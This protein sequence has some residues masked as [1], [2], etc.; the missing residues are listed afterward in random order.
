MYHLPAKNFLAI[1][2]ADHSRETHF[3]SVDFYGGQFG[4]ISF[5][6][7]KQAQCIFHPSA[8]N[9]P[10]PDKWRSQYNPRGKIAYFALSFC[11]L[12]IQAG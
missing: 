3:R 9:L 12:S 11:P 10:N 2:A 5:V 6:T 1:F 7:E 4:D 8:H